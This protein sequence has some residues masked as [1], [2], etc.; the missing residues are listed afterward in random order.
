MGPEVA[1]GLATQR[2]QM[3]MLAAVGWLP[4][5]DAPEPLAETSRGAVWRSPHAMLR[6]DPELWVV[7]DRWRLGYDRAPAS[8]E[9]ERMSAW[10]LDCL[11]ALRTATT[12]K[13]PVTASPS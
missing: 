3:A 4:G 9:Y 1:T 2:E 12:R 7:W 11:F 10:H 6:D 13:P 8:E 5:V